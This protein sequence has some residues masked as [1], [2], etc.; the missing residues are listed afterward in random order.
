MSLGDSVTGTKEFVRRVMCVKSSD[1]T[2]ISEVGVVPLD[3][4]RD[5]VSEMGRRSELMRKLENEDLVDPTSKVVLRRSGTGATTEGRAT[6][7]S[8]TCAC[9]WSG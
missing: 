2:D 7:V 1:F 3:L 8:R 5:I 4:A 6:V 9:S